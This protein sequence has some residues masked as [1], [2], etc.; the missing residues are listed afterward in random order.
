MSVTDKFKNCFE[1]CKIKYNI[2]QVDTVNI[3]TCKRFFSC[4]DKCTYG[5]I[6]N[7]NGKIVKNDIDKKQYNFNR[8]Q[9]LKDNKL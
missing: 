7:E 9:I 8:E 6:R 2:K 1:Q 4:V 3:N 5:I